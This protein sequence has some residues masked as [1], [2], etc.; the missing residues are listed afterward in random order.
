MSLNIVVASSLNPTAGQQFP[1]AFPLIEHSPGHLSPP[2]QLPWDFPLME[3]YPEISPP[4]QFPWA[5]L[6]IE[7]SLDISS[8]DNFH[9]NFHSSNMF[10][11]FHPQTISMGI[12]T[13]RTF[14]WTF[15]PQTISLGISTH[16]TFSRHF[17]LRQFPCEFPLIEYFPH[18]LL[19]YNFPGHFHSSNIFQPQTISLVT[20]TH[21]TLPGHFTPGK[22]SLGIS[23]H[24]KL[25]GHVTLGTISL[26]ISTPDISPPNCRPGQLSFT[27]RGLFVLTR[28]RCR[29]SCKKTG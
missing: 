3:H 2:Q 4:G 12:S 25:P 21:R 1:W 29:S 9:A 18:I 8:S 26:G 13:H 15:H 27:A 7:H 22:L 23:S 5:F 14:P 20:Y 17:I 6:L 24:R 16:R 19:P 11:T 28:S 10:R